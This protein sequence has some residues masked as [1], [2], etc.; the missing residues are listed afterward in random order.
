MD[1]KDLFQTKPLGISEGNRVRSAVISFYSMN[2]YAWNF[3]NLY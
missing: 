1:I 3:L 2:F